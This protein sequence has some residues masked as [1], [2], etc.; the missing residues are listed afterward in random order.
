[1][2]HAGTLPSPIFPASQELWQD[3]LV[4]K[5]EDTEATTLSQVP[6]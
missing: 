6:C 4:P 2:I 1:M 3:F 5:A